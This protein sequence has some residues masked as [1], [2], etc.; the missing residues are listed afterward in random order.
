MQE[1]ALSE[2]DSIYLIHNDIRVESEIYCDNEID[3]M[4]LLVSPM[5]SNIKALFQGYFSTSLE[6]VKADEMNKEERN[7]A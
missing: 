7:R 5:I 2:G 1:H 4:L 6:I 3:T